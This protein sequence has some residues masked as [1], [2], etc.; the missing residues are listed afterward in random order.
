MPELPT[1]GIVILNYQ[2]PSDTLECIE[3]L[4]HCIYPNKDILVVDNGSGGETVNILRRNSVAFQMIETGKNLGYTGGV[5]V[6]LKYFLEK[7]VDYI[8]ILNNDTIV[9]PDFMDHLVAAAELDSD[10]AGCC[11]T[12]LCDHNRDEIWYAG[13]KLIP[14]R[15]LAVHTDKHKKF[16]RQNYTKPIQ[17]SFITGCMILLKTKYLEKIGLED[18]RLFMYLDDIEL[19][20]RISNSGYKM[21]YVPGAIIYHKVLGERENPLKLYYSVRNRFLLINT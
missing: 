4:K 12:I 15:G 8:L 11:G 21:Y 10:V 3:S 19:S 14:W 17:V 20:A 6:G 7:H 5:N 1:V 13:G 2:S 9:E 16:I 18:E